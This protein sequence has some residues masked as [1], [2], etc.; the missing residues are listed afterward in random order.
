MSKRAGVAGKRLA[1]DDSY[2]KEVKA[3]FDK[4]T[5][6]GGDVLD[7]CKR[8]NELLATDFLKDPGSASGKA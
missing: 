8:L 7:R 1:T 4:T 6:Q 5:Q 3:A 2:R